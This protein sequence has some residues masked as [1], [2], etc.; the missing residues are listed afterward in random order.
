MTTEINVNKEKCIRCGKCVKVC[1]AWIFAQAE[2]K[3][4]IEIRNIE[5]CIGCGHCAAVCP[6]SAVEH[7]LFPPKKVH[8]I[9]FDKMPTPEQL[10]LLM[11]ARRSNRAFSKQAVPEEL[12]NQILEAAHRAPTASNLQQVEFT[13]VNDPEKIKMIINTTIDGLTSVAKTLK[14]P[15]LKPILKRIM[16]DVYKYL[17][18]FEQ[19]KTEYEKGNDLILRNATSVIFFSTPK[20]SNFGHADCNLAY[21]NAS[22]MAES[23]G[24]SQFYT[25]FVLTTISRDKKQ[26]IAKALGITGKINAGMGL[27]MPLFKYPNYID[28][29]DIKVIES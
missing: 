9:D 25:G 17:P 24:V 14:N 23:L 4:N 21:Q 28:K 10:M 6:T 1:P 13:V 5:E 2:P 15:L 3:A 29:K 20:R 27:G 16:P 7:S 11:K 12:M 8:A 22:L 19:L 18:K 26:K